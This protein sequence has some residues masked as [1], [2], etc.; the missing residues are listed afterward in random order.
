MKKILLTAALLLLLS[1]AA[2]QAADVSVT[3]PAFE[4]TLNGVKADQAARQY[5]FLVYKDITYA[6]SYTHLEALLKEEEGDGGGQDGL[7]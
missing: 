4:V 5:P 1:P 2:A 7:A 3:L 6:V